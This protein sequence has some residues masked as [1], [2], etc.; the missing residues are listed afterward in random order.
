MFLPVNIPLNKLNDQKDGQNP[1]KDFLTKWTK[2]S[3]PCVSTMR[4]YI[5]QIYKEQLQKIRDAIGS[6]SIYLIVDESTDSMQRYVLNVLVGPLNG[7]EKK[8]FLI[9]TKFLDQTDNATVQQGIMDALNK[10]YLGK[11]KY[12]KLLLIV[13]DRAA[14]MKLAVAKLKETNLFPNLHHVTCL[15]HAIHNLCDKIRKDHILANKFIS[16][17]KDILSKTP[18]RIQFYREITGLSLPPN[19]IITRW[20][21]WIDAAV[22][23]ANNYNQVTKFLE[24]IPNKSKSISTAKLLL[25]DSILK[26]ELITILDYSFLSKYVMKLELENLKVKKQLKIIEKIRD[27]LYSNYLAKFS[28]I[29]EGNPDLIQFTS[30][31]NEF[32]HLKNIKFAPL[33]SVDVERSFSIYKR[34]LDDDRHNLSKKTLKH[35]N[36]IKYNNFL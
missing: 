23:N 15:A 14:Y 32:E 9:L 11:I 2:K 31:S 22:Y 18:Q 10:L 26:D 35:L 27:N 25:K 1:M 12:K 30:S 34:I 4:N 21:S 33:T 8:S 5:K 19:V 36:I 7:M 16:V 6:N 13:S 17:M 29:L 3:Q 24:N 20:G 28:K